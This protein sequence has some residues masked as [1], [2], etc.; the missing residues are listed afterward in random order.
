MV[1]YQYNNTATKCSRGK[2]RLIIEMEWDYNFINVRI[3]GHNICLYAYNLIWTVVK[4]GGMQQKITDCLV[5]ELWIRV[6]NNTVFRCYYIDMKRYMILFLKL[7]QRP[8]IY[9]ENI[10]MM[11]IN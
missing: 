5:I 11:V 7:S 4:T 9:V 3:I 2:Y 6:K 10:F 1:C 8:K